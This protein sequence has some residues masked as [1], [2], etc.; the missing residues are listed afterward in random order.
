VV[1]VLLGAVTVAQAADDAPPPRTY[2]NVLAEAGYSAS[3]I[4]AR[5]DA[6]WQQLF[7]GAPG[8]AADRRDGQS[9]YYQ[10]TPDMAYVEDIG[11]QDVRSEG[12]G[13]AMMI[14]VQ[15]DHQQEF[16]ALWNFAKS[17]MQIKNGVNRYLF[18]WH[19]DTTGR[20]LDAGIAPDGDEWIAIALAFAANRWGNGQGIYEYRREAQQIV[21]AMWHQ[22]DTGGV[23]MFDRTT[24]LPYFSPPG[25][26][27]F[28]DPSYCLPA[29]YKV[30]AELVP[31]DRALWDAA[32]TA[33]QELL[34]RASHPTTGLFPSYS[35][36]AG[37]PTAGW[38]GNN[39]DAYGATFQEDAWR[40]IANVNMDAAWHGTQAWHT[41]LSNRLATFFAARGITSYTSR[42]RL[43][44]TPV[45]QGQNSYEPPHAE[46]LVAMNSTMA[47]S[48]THPD[49]L[50]FVHD[51]WNTP[52]PSGQAR[53]YDGLLYLLGLLYDS[54]NFRIW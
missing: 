16:D 48:A 45:V 9:V 46:G 33:S 21:R 37:A 19:T 39:P 52:V 25:A 22:S 17:K 14:A 6:A 15:L 47:I 27:A 30:F 18:S 54:G 49:R 50:E 43:D 40:A 10:L 20:V 23:D 8:T 53:Y 32:Y 44:G 34:R 38:G 24:H 11:N 1:A 29:F 3:E 41:E 51:L 35:T 7:H 42:Y 4:D 2:P 28:T 26:V 13:Y 12:M 36:F 31:E 5:V